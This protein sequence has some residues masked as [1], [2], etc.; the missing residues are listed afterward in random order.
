MGI[1]LITGYAGKEHITARDQ[2]AYNAGT[3]GGGKYVLK[4]GNKFLY[5]IISNNLIKIRD[6]DLMNQGRHM[7]I[8]AN[9]YEEVVID[10]GIQGLKRND[11]IVIRYT[12][13]LENDIEK[14]EVVLIKGTS[15]DVA[16]DPEYITG[17]IL[18]G[19]PR[20]D[21][22]LYRVRMN[23]INIEGVD[24]LFSEMTNIAELDSR[25]NSLYMNLNQLMPIPIR[26]RQT[27][28]STTIMTNV[29]SFKAP[30]KCVI[31]ITASFDR[32]NGVP[33]TISLEDNFMVLAYNES[34]ID[35]PYLSVSAHVMLEKGNILYVRQKYTNASENNMNIN[36]Y[37]TFVE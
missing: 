18:K 8:S 14:P 22:P 6:G 23:G 4:T 30:R 37:Y 34:E 26:V 1:H 33:K 29:W 9:D 36:G 13:N 16:V 27:F 32:N 28:T 11:L 24:K 2:G 35:S 25:I 17:D 15:G 7:T 21:F 3:V 31:S 19:D 12:K 10:N 5:E 20:D